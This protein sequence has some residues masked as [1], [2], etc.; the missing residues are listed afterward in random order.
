MSPGRRQQGAAL[1]AIVAAILLVASWLLISTLN[2]E[3]GGIEALR[4]G[5]NTEALARAKHALIGYVALQ[6]SKSF[7]NDPGRLPC[8]EAAGNFGNPANE[9]TAAGFC[10]LPAVGRF[11]WRT[12][13]LD[14]LVD[15]HGEPLWYVVA[16]G[17]SKPNATTNT[18]INSN[19]ASPSSGMACATSQLTVDGA[20]NA[21]V[22]L[23]IAPGPAMSVSAAAGCAA[24]SQT[25]PAAGPLD[26]RNYL[27]CENATSPADSTFVTTGPV[28]SFNDQ[29]VKVTAA[30][31]LPAIEAAIAH[32]VEREIVPVLRSA[33]VRPNWGLGG[34]DRVYPYAA[35][36][37]NPDTASFAGPPGTTQGLLPFGY[38]ETFPTSGVACTPGPSAP[39]CN[40]TL[41]SWSNAAPSVVAP[42]IGVSLTS[43]CS[44]WGPTSWAQ[45]TGVYTGLPTSITI[46]G[47]QANGAASLR[48]LRTPLPT[49]FVF[50][51]DLTTFSFTWSQ[52]APSVGFT[53][54]T[55]T[56][57][58]SAAAPAPAGLAGVMYWIY[59]PGNTTSDHSLLDT[60]ASGCLPDPPGC[61]TTSWFARNQW[62]KLLYYAVV[63]GYTAATAPP[64]S[65]TTGTTC[66]SITNVAPAGAQR[67]TLIL[68][69]RSINGSAR[70]SAALG[71]Y[72]E[73][74]N[75]VGAFERQTVTPLSAGTYADT[76]TADAYA[77]PVASLTAGAI[78]QF[79]AANAN[80]GAS[81]LT[82]PATGLRNLVN[83]DGSNLSAAQIQANAV[84][85]VV[86]DGAQFALLK[87]LFNDRIVVLDSN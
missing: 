87:R 1:L 44:Y 66:L 31:L 86:Y 17:W 29:V 38:M 80:T 42:G 27:E 56:V 14:K 45:C 70:P 47:P 34:S 26:L 79:R 36:F 20:A 33:Y 3:S 16:S 54:G 67:A 57:S 28:G 81:T 11:P 19:C 49:G 30:E 76:G 23:I 35:P 43:S 72:L 41:V 8:P 74:G 25:R 46:S 37:G 71:D 9:G 22:A 69:G 84:V 77:L 60:R 15:A 82:T 5:R 7:E 21:A 51:W 64:R 55:F 18:V 39:R 40:P 62:H 61:P 13:G 73:F 52:P 85:Q 48:Q 78:L 59:A 12:L 53:G 65:C 4:K 68:A 10:T 75:A 6:A 32:R 2:A 83:P 58:V 63:P 24:W 50:F